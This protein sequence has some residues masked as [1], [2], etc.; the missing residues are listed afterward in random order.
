[1]QERD[2]KEDADDQTQRNEQCIE[3]VGR[4][5]RRPVGVASDILPK[6]DVECRYGTALSLPLEKDES[7]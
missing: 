2:G 3:Y 6:E 7:T 4:G 5:F 1:M